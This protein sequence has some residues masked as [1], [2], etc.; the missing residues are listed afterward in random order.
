MQRVRGAILFFVLVGVIITAALAT[1]V[2]ASQGA[3][4]GTVVAPFVQTT[5]AKPALVPLSTPLPAPTEAIVE[6]RASPTRVSALS[7]P[8]P[9][10]PLVYAPDLQGQSDD[11]GEAAPPDVPSVSW[12]PPSLPVPLARHPYDHYWFVRP[13]ASNYVNYGLAWYPYGSNGPS[14]NLRV[15]HGIDI[16]NPV[17]VEVHAAADGTVIYSDKGHNNQN[18]TI[19]TYG[20]TV[21]IEHN[22]GYRGQPVY[23]LYA[24]MSVLLVKADDV[25][26]AGDVIGLI[27]A[28]GQ[29]SG[30]HVH[31]EVRVGRDW[32]YSV[33]NPDLWMAPY[34]GTGVI[35]GRIKFADG[36]LANDVDVTVIDLASGATTHRTTSYAGFGV[37]ADDN[38]N[39]NF[40]VPDVPVGHYL[41]TATYGTLTWSGQLEVREGMTN[42]VDMILYTPGSPREGGE[43]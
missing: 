22:Y 40:T 16:P 9:T 6:T 23:T 28:T 42:W 4:E 14:D 35:A 37:N 32:Y 15:H 26:Q 36:S 34:V 1:H 17:G 19:A 38:W 18:E 24:H 2:A 33:R 11:G 10:P 13:V 20:N 12:N 27:G 25:V 31:F 21:V 8:S 39:E 7:D 30:P 5:Q 43:G 29:V 41:I 3:T